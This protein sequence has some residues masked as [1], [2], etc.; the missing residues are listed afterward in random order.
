MNLNEGGYIF[1]VCIYV[2]QENIKFT[3]HNDLSIGRYIFIHNL[4]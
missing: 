3:L 4:K 1:I 2:E